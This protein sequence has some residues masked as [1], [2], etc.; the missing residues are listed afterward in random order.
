MDTKMLLHYDLLNGYNFIVSQHN[1]NK[2]HKQNTTSHQ[3]NNK[4][5]HIL[6]DYFNMNVSTIQWVTWARVICT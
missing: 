1:P 4:L 5:N 6:N 3:M 2:R